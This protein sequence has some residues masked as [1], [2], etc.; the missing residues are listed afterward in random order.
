M[1]TIFNPLCSSILS[2]C[3]VEIIIMLSVQLAS[4]VDHYSYGLIFGFNTFL[5]LVLMTAL[6]FT[7]A[8]KHGLD[9]GIREQV[10]IH[11]L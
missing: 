10:H 6:T 3:P 2:L 7:V 11:T 5:S 4:A 9:L 1:Q 8:D